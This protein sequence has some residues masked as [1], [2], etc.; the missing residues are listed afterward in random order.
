LPVITKNPAFT[1]GV[2]SCFNGPMFAKYK[3][4]IFSQICAVLAIIS[5]FLAYAHHQVSQSWS[6]QM[7]ASFLAFAALLF[8]AEIKFI[9][10][11]L[12]TR[13]TTQA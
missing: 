11:W 9:I 3:K 1:G 4:L 10:D 5:L 6:E 2:F 7:T 12:K 13:N 8:G